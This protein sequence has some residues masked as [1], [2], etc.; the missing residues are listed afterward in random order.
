MRDDASA[1]PARPVVLRKAT[2]V[3]NPAG[4][5]ADRRRRARFVRRLSM[6]HS[7]LRAVAAQVG[8]GGADR[9]VST[10]A[11][12]AYRAGLLTRKQARLLGVVGNVLYRGPR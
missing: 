10:V 1:S 8:G 5:R 11:Y 2:S 4:P 9:K 7:R 6:A 12:A 3:P